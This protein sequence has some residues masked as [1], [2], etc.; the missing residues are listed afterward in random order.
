MEC[1]YKFRLYPNK[2]QENLIQHTFGCVRYVYNHFLA[3]RKEAYEKTGKGPSLF[4][5]DKYLTVLKQ[6]LDWLREPDKCSLQNALRNLDTAYKNFFRRVKKGIKP[7]GYPRFKRKHDNCKSYR[8]NYTN[9]NIKVLDDKFIQLPKL[10]LI[11]CC[12]HRKVIGRILSATV[13]QNPSG[14]YYVSLCCTDVVFKNLPKTNSAIGVDLGIKDLVVTSDGKKYKNSHCLKK[15]KKRLRRA[16]Q[17][18]FRKPKDS[19]NRVKARKRVARLYQRVSNQRRDAMQKMT[20]ELIRNNDII[21]IEN[22]NIKGMMKNH[23]LAFSLSD[24]SFFEFKRELK[25]KAAWY[26]RRIVEVNSFYPSSQLCSSCGY[27]NKEVKDLSIREWTC[28]ECGTIH[29]RD[30]NAAKNILKEGL[31]LLSVA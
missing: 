25:Y 4:E 19:K 29:D 2:I 9:N 18:L 20:T 24:A 31:R 1:A 8:T 23:H 22:L 15:R 3:E 30:I 17:R 27:Q 28:P 7:Y 12:I 5:Q 21:C 6:N 11:K 10:G 14:E 16:M 26:G 13:F